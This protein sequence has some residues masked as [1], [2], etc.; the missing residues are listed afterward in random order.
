MKNSAGFDSEC[1]GLTDYYDR[2][3]VWVKTLN[4]ITFNPLRLQ[5]DASEKRGLVR[6]DL[7]ALIRAAYKNDNTSHGI[8]DNKNAVTAVDGLRGLFVNDPELFK[9]TGYFDRCMTLARKLIV[10]LNGDLSNTLDVGA[11]AYV[12][13]H[14]EDDF[15]N[16]ICKFLECGCCGKGFTI[17]S[18]ASFNTDNYHP[19]ERYEHCPHCGAP[20][21][22]VYDAQELLKTHMCKRL[23][24]NDS[25]SI[26]QA[27]D[28][29]NRND[30]DGFSTAMVKAI[31][32][33]R[34][35]HGTNMA[36][37]KEE[38]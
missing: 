35:A 8:S 5:D 6:A 23:F 20:I 13:G 10:R 1:L 27:W 32:F 14:E 7:N 36:D 24:E 16:P 4:E 22:G 30:M 21:T 11:E 26:M 9:D 37:A 29:I 38:N 33:Y 2:G 15:G 31:E 25:K 17:R 3:L 28:A 18:Q 34:E 12:T 19:D